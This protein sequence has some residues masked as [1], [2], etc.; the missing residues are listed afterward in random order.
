MVVSADGF[1]ARGPEDDMSWTGRYDK[2]VFRAL[3]GVGGRFAVGSATHR[4][5]PDR[6]EGRTAYVLSRTMGMTLEAFQAHCPEGWLIGGQTV[7]LAALEKGF[8]SEMHIC[9][10]DRP[11]GS[12]VPFDPAFLERHPNGPAM[13]TRVGDTTVEVYR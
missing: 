12:G 7:A 11:L 10:S 5:M 3:T 6:L 9:W 8:L 13:G 1:V 4:L 2:A